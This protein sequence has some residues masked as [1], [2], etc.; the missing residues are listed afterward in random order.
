M[1]DS[2]KMLAVAKRSGADG[3][4]PGYGFLSERAGFARAVIDAGL[5]WIG[6]NPQTIDVLG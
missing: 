2:G 6:H 1:L 5:I 4:D 3:G